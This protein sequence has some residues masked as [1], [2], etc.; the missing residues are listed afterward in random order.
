V[1]AGRPRR[2]DRDVLEEHGPAELDGG[3]DKEQCHWG[4]Q[5]K[6]DSRRAAASRIRSQQRT[7]EHVFRPECE[8]WQF[9]GSAHEWADLEP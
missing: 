8:N 1:P 4:Y 7:L 2:I 6:F 3:Q 5:G 9:P